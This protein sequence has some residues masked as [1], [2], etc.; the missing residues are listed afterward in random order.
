MNIRSNMENSKVLF[1]KSLEKIPGG[2]NSPV[3]A[4]G[5]VG[6]SP[7]FIKS[8][9]AD[10]IYDVDGNEFIDYVCSW[11]PGILG[12]AHP[13]VI[14]AVKKA[15]VDGLT[16]GAPTKKELELA[17]LIT[18][19]MP[20]IEKVRLV[21]SGTEA[22]MSAIRTARGYTGRDMIIKF[23]GNYHGHS[24]GLLVKAGSA[25]LTTAVPDSAG[26]PASYTQ[27]TLVAEYN[28]EDSVRELMEQYGENVAA[29][30]VEP[31]AANMGVVPPKEGFLKFL[32][33]I[34][35]KYETVL[36]FDEVITGFRLKFGGAQEYFGVKP[37]MTTLGKIVGGGMPI[38]A[39]G[40]KKEIMDRVSPTG[41][42][43][44]A[45]TLSGNPIATTAGIETL[46][47]LKAHPEYYKQ[48]DESAKKLA[49]AYRKMAKEKN[50]PLHVNQ[51]GS[52]LS[53]FQT[54]EVVDDYDSALT[55]DTN[56]YTEYFWK[57]LDNG[58]YV[59]PAQFEAMFV[60][61]AH[62][63]EDIERTCEVI[64]L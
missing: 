44:Q 36:I 24:D 56:A 62:T 3:R 38:A 2:V 9:N 41:P 20:S 39:Y 58:I 63:K 12:H 29:I 55:S 60:S 53:A 37:D 54:G 26:V 22:T 15:C 5:S 47:I 23:R 25:A 52:L 61:V 21:N 46:K 31:V 14:E 11:G 8:A 28:N 1:E 64:S 50:I 40:G 57:M 48:I 35:L 27:N 13:Q 16:F 49:D 19:A 10:H 30:I 51:I 4:F 18:D 32:R 45:G 17:E 7:L 59:A 6:G 33:D 42:V 34:T 43:Y